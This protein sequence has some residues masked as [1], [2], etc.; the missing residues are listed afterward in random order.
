MN[1]CRLTS[2]EYH[3]PRTT[4]VHCHWVNI[5]NIGQVWSIGVGQSADLMNSQSRA[6]NHPYQRR[7]SGRVR[8]R[9]H[10]SVTNRASSRNMESDH[11]AGVCIDLTGNDSLDM[12]DVIDLTNLST[13]QSAIDADPVVVISPTDVDNADT[14]RRA[15]PVSRRHR[16]ILRL[17]DEADDEDSE[18]SED[19]T[20]GEGPSPSSSGGSV[21]GRGRDRS[22]ISVEDLTDDE[23][24]EVP[25]SVP[26]SSSAA[27]GYAT[28]K[29]TCPVCLETDVQIRRNRQLYSTVCGHIF[30]STCIVQAIETQ[31]MCPTCRKRLSKRQIHKI[32][33]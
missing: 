6:R 11:D 28:P 29:V 30:C 23:L 32:Y 33:L 16:I 2:L 21:S 13:S 1:S 26:P 22:I 3:H 17:D 7:R 9:Q 4:F 19:G 24:P 10:I 27:S 15:E 31:R 5:A 14:H 12:G 20:G 25:F 8:G 18:D